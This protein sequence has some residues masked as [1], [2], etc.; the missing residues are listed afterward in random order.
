MLYLQTSPEFCMKR[1]VAAG[2]DRIFQIAHAFRRDEVGDQHNI[3]F[4]MLEWYEVGIP[5]ADARKFLGDLLITHF[6]GRS[7]RERTYRQAFLDI[8]GLD[9]F[10]AEIEDLR[11]CAESR[12]A[13]DI[14][15]ALDFDRD[16]WLNL[17]FSHVVQPA[18][19]SQEW[20]DIVFDWPSSQSALAQVRENDLGAEVAERFEAFVNG[21]E[22]ANGYHELLSA[23][24]LV[25]RNQKNNEER[26]RLG[27]EVY[28]VE[29][30][31]TAAMRAG[32]PTCCGVALGVDRLLMAR[33]GATEIGQVMAFP[34]DIA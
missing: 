3:E 21:I 19:G 16:E 11:S 20:I 22:L 32:L 14:A 17:L 9:P 2:A 4:Q 28:P 26:L 34:F 30:R 18:L 1:I 24:E 12:A 8:L 29:S 10:R 5:Y 25:A 27:R 33:T 13:S 6:D 15:N 23:V 7:V 31:L